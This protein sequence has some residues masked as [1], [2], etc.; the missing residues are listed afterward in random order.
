MIIN[1]TSNNSTQAVLLTTNILVAL[2]H[3]IV[4]PYKRKLLNIFD[5]VVLQTMVFISVISLLDSVSSTILS[6][7][8]L[9]L[10]L[11]PL[12]V[13]AAMEMVIYKET[14]KKIV[15]YFKPK[16]SV[17]S[18]ASPMSDIGIIIDDDMRKNATIV[19]M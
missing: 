9:L 8:I 10:M 5:G 1:S 13:F 14:I 4:K 16:K 17:D 7:V 18:G 2:I 19:D 6:A 11:L 12:I 15:D 3:I